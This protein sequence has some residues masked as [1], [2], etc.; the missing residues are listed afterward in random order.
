[1][2]K[3]SVGPDKP[4]WLKFIHQKTPKGGGLMEATARQ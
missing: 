4:K 3:V 2:K 1:M